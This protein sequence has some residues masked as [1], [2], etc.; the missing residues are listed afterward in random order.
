M[1]SEGNPKIENEEDLKSFLFHSMRLKGDHLP[2]YHIDLSY[3]SNSITIDEIEVFSD[4]LELVL[5]EEASGELLMYGLDEDL[6][7]GN[8]LI[9]CYDGLRCREVF[10]TIRPTFEGQTC[11]QNAFVGMKIPTGIG[12]YSNYGEVIRD[13]IDP[14]DEDI[15]AVLPI[16]E[17]YENWNE[18]QKKG[19]LQP[20]VIS[21]ITLIIAVFLAI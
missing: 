18:K 12:G 3:E 1:D 8:F 4:K 10:E 15:D 13:S 17:G 11:F 9:R 21:V 16:P 7:R 2:N 20:L 14:Y 5:F 19:C 6:K